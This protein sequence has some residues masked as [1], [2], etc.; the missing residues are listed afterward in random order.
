MFR[1][2]EPAYVFAQHVSGPQRAVV[3]QDPAKVKVTAL[4]EAAL[5][6]LPDFNGKSVGHERNDWNCGSTEDGSDQDSFSR[7]SSASYSNPGVQYEA[8]ESPDQYSELQEAWSTR[9]QTSDESTQ[10]SS[11]LI[12]CRWHKSAGTVGSISADGHTFKKTASGQKVVINDRGTPME[13]SSICMVFDSTLRCGGL[14]TYQ[15]TIVDGEL[16][17]ADGAGFVFDSKVRRNNIQQM[18][19]VFLNKRGV[20]CI[21]DR[22]NVRKLTAQLPPLEP[23]LCLSLTVDLDNSQLQFVISSHE[24]R[25]VIAPQNTQGLKL[26]GVT[27]KYDVLSRTKRRD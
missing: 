18:R 6:F 16:G 21:R 2:G 3:L 17:P 14:H 24:G 26:G 27:S 10:A 7:G 5:R 13:L 1:T 22:H 4:D 20:I 8:S 12:L 25:V 23:G 19:T 15:Y 11:K 9:V